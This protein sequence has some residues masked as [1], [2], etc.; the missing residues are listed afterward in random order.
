MKKIGVDYVVGVYETVNRHPGKLPGASKIYTKLIYSK[1][2]HILLG[3]EIKGG[4]VV[5]ELVNMYSVIIQNRMTDMEIDTLQIGT[6]PLLT[7]SP[8]A[9]PVINATVDAIMKWYKK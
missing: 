4:D 1:Y 5:G 3:A 9:Y 8:I 7:A 2:S 6:H